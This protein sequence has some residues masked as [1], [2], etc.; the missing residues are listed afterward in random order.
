M[1]LTGLQDAVAMS[2][3]AARMP[4]IDPAPGIR[5]L[6]S[7]LRWFP[8]RFWR[9]PLLRNYPLKVHRGRGSVFEVDGRA[10]FVSLPHLVESYSAK[11]AGDRAVIMLQDAAALRIGDRSVVSPG[12]RF[13]IGEGASVTVG[14]RTLINENCI[15]YSRDSVSIGDDCA[16]SWGVRIM[17]TDFHVLVKEGERLPMEA[18]VRIGDHV[19]IGSNATVLKGVSIGDD[20]VVG[21]GAVVTRDVPPRTVVAG[22]PARP[23]HEGMGWHWM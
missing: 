18:P 11:L 23:I 4:L 2:E 21:A 7:S 16:I 22:N 12:A 8:R 14:S 13:N 3:G 17:D 1:Y 20:A 6:L 9:F 19:W 10:L 15:I 5:S